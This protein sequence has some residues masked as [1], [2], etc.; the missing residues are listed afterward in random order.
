M[1][2]ILFLPQR[3]GDVDRFLALLPEHF[4]EVSVAPETH[5][6]VTLLQQAEYDTVVVS[7]E[8][9]RGESRPH[10]AEIFELARRLAVPVLLFPTHGG[11][12][13]PLTP[14]GAAKRRR[15]NGRNGHRTRVEQLIHDVIRPVLEREG[16]DIEFIDLIGEQVIV[17]LLGMCAACPTARVR[18]RLEVEKFLRSEVPGV[19]FVVVEESGF[20]PGRWW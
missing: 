2:R 15:R 9:C 16:G 10:A 1:H 4:Y 13:E 8:F 20:P 17:R 19:K 7:A 18:H 12:L 6:A 3:Q 14:V 5:A 11:A